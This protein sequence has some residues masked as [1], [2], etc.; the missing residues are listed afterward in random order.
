LTL[1][2][3]LNLSASDLIFPQN[4]IKASVLPDPA[5]LIKNEG[6]NKKPGLKGPG[7]KRNTRG[8]RNTCSGASQGDM[9]IG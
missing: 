6:V 2:I 4:I 7:K 3:F 9:G 5:G 8:E 1:S